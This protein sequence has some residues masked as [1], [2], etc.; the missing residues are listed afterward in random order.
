MD[1]CNDLGFAIPTFVAAATDQY[2]KPRTNFVCSHL[3]FVFLSVFIHSFFPPFFLLQIR[4]CLNISRVNVMV[5]LKLTNQRVYSL[6]MQQ[7]VQKNGK[8]AQRKVLVTTFISISFFIISFVSFSTDF[9]CV[10]RAFAHNVGLP[11]K[12]PEEYFLGESVA[13]FEWDSIDSKTIVSSSTSTSTTSASSTKFWSGDKALTSKEQEIVV[14]V[15]MPA[16][17]KSTFAKSFLVKEGYVHV[18]RDTLGTKEKCFKAARE[19]M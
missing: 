8:V 12:T 15:G 5:V 18:N 13:K 4:R 7:V 14:L 9:S 19:E 1:I 6:E 2:R 16:A 3:S 17:G 10:D 11:F